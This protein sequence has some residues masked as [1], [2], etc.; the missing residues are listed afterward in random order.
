MAPKKVNNNNNN[1]KAKAKSR[2]LGDDEDFDQILSQLKKATRE[3]HKKD[4]KQ[5]KAEEAAASAATER[6][7][8]LTTKPHEFETELK[9]MHQE[10]Y[11]QNIIQQMMESNQPYLTA[12]NTHVTTDSLEGKKLANGKTLVSSIAVAEMQGWRKSMEDAHC[13]E[14][15]LFEDAAFFAVFDGHAGELCAKQAK[16]LLPALVLKHRQADQAN[17]SNFL[18]AYHELDAALRG[19]L[20]DD[21]GCTAVSVLVTES[22]LSCA[23]VGDSRAVLGRRL[24]N[25]S[26][27]TVALSDDHKPELDHER[28]RIEEA[29][30][31]VENNRVN[32][33][34]AMSRAIGDFSYKKDEGRPVEGQLVIPTPDIMTVPRNANDA[35][36]VVACD[37]IFDVLSNEELV[38]SVSKKIEEQRAAEKLAANAKLS[39]QSVAKICEKITQ[40]CLA[41]ASPDGRGPAAAAGTDNMT[42]MIVLF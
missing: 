6:R 35:F 8:Q 7:Q 13:T 4:P 25:G 23:N 41:P 39:P 29:G 22:V 5:K 30:G 33:M 38:A 2:D 16:A 18:K 37:G 42:I 36:L 34:L 9:R 11:I 15:Q 40:E 12:P 31:R 24:E 21:S 14:L 17:P 3:S 26:Y 10:R 19:R 20:K 27:Q 1:T 32:G 28:A